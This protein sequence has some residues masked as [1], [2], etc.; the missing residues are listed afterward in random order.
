MRAT[1]EIE[2]E[3]TLATPAFAGWVEDGKKCVDYLR[4]NRD[5]GAYE[6]TSK[7]VPYHPVDPCGIRIPSLRGILEFWHRSRLG[8]LVGPEVFA[9]QRRV[10]GSADSGQGVLL[11]PVGKPEFRQGEVRY[12]AAEDREAV[13]YLGYGPLQLLRVAR[14]GRP[15]GVTVATSYN[16]SHKREAIRAGPGHATRF[17]FAA[18]G[19]AAQLDEVK[20]ALTLLHLFGGIGA[21]SRRG[22]GSVMVAGIDLPPDSKASGLQ[23]WFEQ[24][25]KGALGERPNRPGSGALPSFTAFSAASRAFLT[26]VR[27]RYEEV[28]RDFHASFKRVRSFVLNKVDTARTAVKDHGYEVTDAK[29]VATAV[30]RVPLR[31]AFGMPYSPQHPVQLPG[32]PWSIEYRGRLA[33]SDDVTRRASPLF[34]KVLRLAERSYVGVVLFLASSFFGDPNRQIGA[35]GG[36]ATQPFPGYGA[37]TELLDGSVASS[38]WTEISLG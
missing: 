35:E 36:S 16:R 1:T 2:F 31:I 33:G 19:S 22:W 21:R 17:R 7:E 5:T 3:I 10:F 34:L 18:R 4:K 29:Q 13:L 14:Q 8:H 25:A 37:V 12:E 26:P 20:R 23:E 24:A 32:R 11:R 30:T 15:D 38:G 6:P 28:F 9:S 27:D